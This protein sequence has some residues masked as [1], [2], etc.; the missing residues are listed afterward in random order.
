M[1]PNCSHHWVKYDQELLGLAA[2]EYGGAFFN[3]AFDHL[4]D[5]IKAGT[6]HPQELVVAYVPAEDFK[7]YDYDE[8]ATH[9]TRNLGSTC[10]RTPT[11]NTFAEVYHMMTGE[12]M[13]KAK[14]VHLT[15][16]GRKWFAWALQ[17]WARESGAQLVLCVGWN[18]GSQCKQRL[19]TPQITQE[20]TKQRIM[21]NEIRE[22]HR[23][24]HAGVISL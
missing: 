24:T 5:W 7:D 3:G 21:V 1:L 12:N 4:K 16:R 15:E 11:I 2:G 23:S 10:I 22:W 6:A 19:T 18:A 20:Y 14:G 13:I 8:H 9:Q 17:I